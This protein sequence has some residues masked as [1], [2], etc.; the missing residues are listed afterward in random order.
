MPEKQDSEQIAYH[1]ESLD[2]PV[3]ERRCNSYYV[4]FEP[5]KP[6]EVSVHEH[7]GVELILVIKGKLGLTIEE[8]EHKLQE[9]DSVYFDS[10][11]PHGYRGIGKNL[12]QAVL[13]SIPD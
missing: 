7:P 1:F 11:A 2:F 3:V 12:C 9:G 5:L 8:E 6:G 4:E 10:N 13:V